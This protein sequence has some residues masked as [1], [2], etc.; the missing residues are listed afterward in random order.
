MNRVGEE[1]QGRERL[2][3]LVPA[4]DAARLRAD[5]QARRATPS[6][7]EAWD[8]HAEALKRRWKAR[9]GTANGTAAAASTTARRS[10]RTTSDEC[11][12]DSIAQSW[13]VL[14]G[15]G[16]PAR[17]KTAMDA[18]IEDAGRRRARRSSSCSRRPSSKTRQGPGLHQELSAG[19]AREWR[20]VHPCRDLVRHRAGRDGPRRRR[21]SLLLDAQP[22]Q[23]RAR[24]GGGRA[25]PRRA[26]CGRRRHLCRRRT[27]AGA[28]AGPGTPARPAGST[29][30]RSRAS[31]ASATRQGDR[32]SSPALPSHWDGYSA[33]LQMLDGEIKVRVIRDKKTK[34]ISLK[35]WFEENRRRS[36]QSGDKTEVTVRFLR[37]SR[38]G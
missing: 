17:S 6:A 23:P 9:P 31:S 21:L 35:S 20:P 38:L 29:A 32:V 26:L 2:A 16:D 34:S 13:S 28:A 8:K 1:R 33:T 7:R 25:L 19:R 24:R 22:G 37:K 36:S 15:E 5:R 4:E 30:R 3:R 12:I 27:R 10:A 18:A 11:Q 14:S